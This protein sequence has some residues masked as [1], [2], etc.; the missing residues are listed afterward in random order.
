M[1]QLKDIAFWDWDYLQSLPG[2][3]HDWID[4]KD[5]RYLT[6]DNACLDSLSDY[7][8]AF[9]NYD[10]GYLVI[11]MTKTSG[12]THA[13]DSGV[14]LKHPK[15][16]D[17]KEWLEDKLPGLVDPP[18][19]KLAVQL[20]SNPANAA[21]GV[22]AIY[23]PESDLAPHQGSKGRFF[24]RRGSKL[25]AIT[26][27]EVFDIQARQKNPVLDASVAIILRPQNEERR[28]RLTLIINNNSDA[29]CVHFGARLAIPLLFQHLYLSFKDQG[30]LDDE[31]KASW[32]LSVMNPGP[33]FPRSEA[34]FPIE[35][36]SMNGIDVSVKSSEVVKVRLYAD[37]A[38]FRDFEFP[39]TEVCKILKS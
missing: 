6:L 2:G 35:F 20:I 13:P 16:G 32:I 29:L 22:V 36:D 15:N 28:S 19:P 34:V 14:V 37:A 21:Q 31:E 4:Y 3:E 10:G 11:G 8:S 33:I 7:L 12:T 17:L 26:T 30:Y 18:L 23:I 1:S 27:R 5:S 38:P 9:A 39:L 25:R 24:S